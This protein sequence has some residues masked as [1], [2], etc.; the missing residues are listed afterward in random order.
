MRS[1][2]SI[3]PFQ[4]PTFTHF[5]LSKTLYYP[6]VHYYG[7]ESVCECIYYRK[8]VTRRKNE[9]ACCFFLSRLGR[10]AGSERLCVYT[11]KCMYIDTYLFK[12]ARDLTKDVFRYVPQCFHFRHARVLCEDRKDL[13]NVYVCVCMY[14]KRECLPL[15]TTARACVCVCVPVCGKGC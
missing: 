1:C 14:T 4:P 7:R 8:R 10:R 15:Y 9:C 13:C 5:S 6:S 11:H 12:E 2:V 3:V